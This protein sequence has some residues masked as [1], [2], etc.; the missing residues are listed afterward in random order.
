MNPASSPYRVGKFRD[1]TLALSATGEKMSRACL[2]VNCGP[3]ESTTDFTYGGEGL[4]LENGSVLGEKQPFSPN[5]LIF[6]DVDFSQVKGQSV[7]YDGPE[8]PVSLP[9]PDFSQGITFA[10]KV[11]KNPFLPDESLLNEALLIQSRGLAKRFSH[12]GAASMVLGLSGGLDSTLALLV[13]YETAKLLGLETSSI[14]A[15]SR[16]CFGTTRRTQNNARNLALALNVDFRQISIKKAVL[17]HFRD[18]GQDENL[19]NSVY[20]NSQARERTQILMD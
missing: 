3:G 5:K 11:E 15:V 18:I 13:C 14:R 20:E 8:I 12:C 2:F 6:A 1:T 10:G 4:I 19:H 17:Q 7:K 16:P 9:L